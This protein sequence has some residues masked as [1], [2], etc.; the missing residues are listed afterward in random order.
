MKNIMIILFVF[1]ACGHKKEFLNKEEVSEFK[2]NIEL[3]ESYHYSIL[4]DSVETKNFIRG[5]D[6]LEK[7]TGCKSYSERNWFIGYLSDSLFKLDI[8]MWKGW[9]L[10]HTCPIPG[11]VSNGSF[12]KE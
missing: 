11:N 7:K 12:D 3:I 10:D 9:L 1:M 4:K 5:I 6:F 2:R 8:K